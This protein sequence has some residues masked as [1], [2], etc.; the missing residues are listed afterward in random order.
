M[1]DVRFNSAT[2]DD[3]KRLLRF[4][5]ERA[6]TAEDLIAAQEAVDSIEA[7][8]HRHLAATPYSFRNAGRRSTRR[9]LI[10][11][12]GTTGHVA[13]YEIVSPTQ[14]LVLAVRHQRDEDCH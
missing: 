6:E 7:T 3:L 14:V 4:L 10:V 9:E 2:R 13:L 11:P 12:F 8:A 1:F 5:L